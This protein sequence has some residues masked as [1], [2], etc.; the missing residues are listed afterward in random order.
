MSLTVVTHQIW[1]PKWL[2][3][4][5]YDLSTEQSNASGSRGGPEYGRREGDSNCLS[6][7]TARGPAL[8]QNPTTQAQSLRVARP[9]LM[10][11]SMSNKPSSNPQTSTTRVEGQSSAAV[12]RKRSRPAKKPPQ[13]VRVQHVPTPAQAAWQRQHDLL[14]RKSRSGAP[15]P[16]GRVGLSGYPNYP[17]L[18]S[19]TVP[20]GTATVATS[21]ANR[22]LSRHQLCSLK[23]MVIVLL[24]FDTFLPTSSM[25]P[26][27][28]S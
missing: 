22:N 4:G 7:A 20:M 6:A 24:M 1:T 2:D 27:P 17:Q 9:Q 14:Q 10:K 8:E 11:Q 12:K 13:H 3:R 23:A 5:E 15:S 25:S 21:A 19:S 16:A 26:P 28:S 18:P